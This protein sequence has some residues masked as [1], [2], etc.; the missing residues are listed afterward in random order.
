MDH[1]FID[2]NPHPP[3]RRITRPMAEIDVCSVQGNPGLYDLGIRLGVYFQLIATFICSRL[4]PE[5]VVTV[6]YANSIFLLAVFAAL[7]SATVDQSVQYVRF[8]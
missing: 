3:D 2:E 5:E 8:L 1:P 6:L 7:A 4:L